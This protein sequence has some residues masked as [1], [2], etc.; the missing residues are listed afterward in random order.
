MAFLRDE[1]KAMLLFLKRKLRDKLMSALFSTNM[2]QSSF[3]LPDK[4]CS[5]HVCKN[6][7]DQDVEPS[8]KM[9]GSAITNDKHRK[10]S[11]N[12]MCRLIALSFFTL[13]W[14]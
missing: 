8:N 1:L 6:M 7:S 2:N 5:Y 3:Y 14:S 11:P 12:S 9:L 13:P 10:Y 4:A